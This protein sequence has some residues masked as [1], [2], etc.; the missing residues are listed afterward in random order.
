MHDDLLNILC[1]LIR[2]ILTLP[3]ILDSI[4]FS[5][6]KVVAFMED[7]LCLIEARRLINFWFEPF[8]VNVL[9][10]LSFLS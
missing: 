1:I 7:L 10:F 5:V 6:I 8:L 3:I 9:P 4:S 2:C